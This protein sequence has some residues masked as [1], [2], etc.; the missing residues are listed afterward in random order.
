LS[1]IITL[2]DMLYIGYLRGLEGVFEVF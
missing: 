2:W 1:L